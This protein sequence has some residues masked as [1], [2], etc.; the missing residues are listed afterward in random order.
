LRPEHGKIRN[1]NEIKLMKKQTVVLSLCGLLGC[2]LS[3]SAAVDVTVNGA[4]YAITTVDYQGTLTPDLFNTL[5]S[6]VWYNVYG[7]NA[8][9]YFNV[10]YI[11]AVLASDPNAAADGAEQAA[12]N[13]EFVRNLFTP[14]FGNATS[15]S[16]VSD[17]SGLVDAGTTLNS[18]VNQP[19]LLAEATLVTSA[20]EP[21]AYGWAA[22][23]L[24]LVC[25]SVGSMRKFRKT[26]AA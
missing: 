13:T 11:N 8:A 14:S 19:L 5:T 18:S 10:D 21:A 3:A 24:V 25:G 15:A 22:S 4:T 7:P 23:T 9:Y 26:N 12:Y 16:A 20:P 6:Q 2:A 17:I 1:E